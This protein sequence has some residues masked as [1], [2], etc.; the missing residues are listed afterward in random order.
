[1]V[2]NIFL[3][4]VEDEGVPSLLNLCSQMLDSASM[5]HELTQIKNNPI[6]SGFV[7]FTIQDPKTVDLP[8]IM[9][10]QAKGNASQHQHGCE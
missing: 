5:L 2:R 7:F 3:V 9:Q 1:M 8:K 6:V 10:L 4:A